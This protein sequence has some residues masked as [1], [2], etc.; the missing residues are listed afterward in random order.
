MEEYEDIDIEDLASDDILEKHAD[1]YDLVC[2]EI[3]GKG[4]GYLDDLLE[5]ERELA[6]REERT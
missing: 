5:L 2:G 1:L 6:I 3:T 4:R